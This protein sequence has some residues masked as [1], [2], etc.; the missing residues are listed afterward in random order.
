[1]SPSPSHLLDT[2]VFSQPV[3]DHPCAG[4]L[5]RWAELG[6]EATCTSAVCLG[7]LLQ[8]L[9]ARGSEK[10]WRRYRELLSHR[11]PVLPVDEAVAIQFGKL[12]GE[13]K[14]LGTPKPVVDLWIAA[15]AKRHGLIVVSLNAKHFRGIPGVAVE[16]WA[17]S[18]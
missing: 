13:L 18:S 8:G 1:M 14:R 12:S 3:K 9:E 15:T 5:E 10:F 7:E 6:D 4:V 11:Y 2:S 16:D 17:A